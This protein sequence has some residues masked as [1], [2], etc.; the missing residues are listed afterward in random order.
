MVPQ[1]LVNANIL[2]ALLGHNHSENALVLA[3]VCK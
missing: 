3:L 2:L 1:S